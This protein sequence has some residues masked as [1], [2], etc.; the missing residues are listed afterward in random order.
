MV[1]RAVQKGVSCTST[2]TGVGGLAVFNKTLHL[3][4]AD[5]RI[6]SLTLPR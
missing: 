3:S 4:Q 6:K 2:L 5:Y 1:A